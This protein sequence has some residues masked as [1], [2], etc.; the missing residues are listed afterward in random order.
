M[1]RPFPLRPATWA[2]RHAPRSVLVFYLSVEAL[3]L[4]LV[5]ALPS[6]APTGLDWLHFAVLLG[7]GVAQAELSRR[8][9]RLRR[10]LV[11]TVNADM[12]SVWTFAGALV[13]PSLLAALL[14][15]GVY[16]HLI[17]R[18]WRAP[19]SRPTNRIVFSASTVV[20]A[21]L[22]VGPVLRAVAGGTELDMGPRGLVAVA[23]AMLAYTLINSVLVFVGL[24]LRHPDSP[25]S[26]LTGGWDNNVLELATLCLGAMTAAVL[27]SRPYLVPLILLPIVMLHRSMLMR[28]F[29]EMATR[30][31]KTGVL[32]AVAWHDVATRE[33]DRATRQLG[34]F[35]V[36]MIDI[37]HFKRVND[38]HGH[39]VGD[40]VLKHVAVALEQHV[41]DYDSVGRFGG[42]EFVV[43]LPET[44]HADVISVAE[45]LRNAI[46]DLV[47]RDQAATVTDLS[48]SIGVAVYPHD[49]LVIDRLLMAA[50]NALYVAK[51]TGRN[52]VVSLA[53]RG[54]SA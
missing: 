45:R 38:T 22:A 10:Y 24:R 2:L 26:T 15:V 5:F 23:L 11:G 32:N 52:R 9:E 30:D 20:L 46:G 48:A 7:L 25:L 34:G 27:A 13:L 17:G 33:L 36:L 8:T 37:D 43:L 1:N 41:R 49:G 47:I 51:R 4:V 18:V 29:Q 35:G 14:T 44:P 3:A 12:A 53:D 16:L 40:T 42:E 39:L 21:C 50:D 28:Q 6:P 19:S 31:Q 54:E